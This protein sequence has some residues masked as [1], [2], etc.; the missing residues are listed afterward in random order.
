[1]DN[2][3]DGYDRVAEAY[4]A[5]I[6]GELAYKP[7]DRELLM[8]FAEMARG[9]I[10]DAGCGPGHIARFLAD[11]GAEVSGLDLSPAMVAQ[12]Q[13]LNPNLRFAT[14][15]MTELPADGALA[16]I[17]AFYAVIHIPREQQVAMFANWRAALRPGGYALVSFHIGEEDRHLDAFF[18][19]SVSLDFLFFTSDEI[20]DRLSTA[21]LMIVERYE[22]DPY[23]DYEVA[24]RRGYIL[25]RRPG[26][27]DG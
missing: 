19:Q 21:G 22:R 20:V 7:F 3:R 11:Q 24:T 5:R 23:P 6:A 15:S 14:G 17:V 26:Q 10:L 12:A 2:L 25:A 1:M 13:T 8:R 4:T 27:A 18:G 9:P 16:G